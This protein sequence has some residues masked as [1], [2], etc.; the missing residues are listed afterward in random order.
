[1]LLGRIAQNRTTLLRSTASKAAIRSMTVLNYSSSSKI[2]PKHK[3]IFDQ[4]DLQFDNKGVFNGTW[5]GSGPI[6]E[7]ISPADG[8]V[9]G[10]VQT[11]CRVLSISLDRFSFECPSHADEALPSSFSMS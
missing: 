2:S 7:S 9:I 8:S 3:A 5:G 1:M 10:R 11:V 6:V 4:L